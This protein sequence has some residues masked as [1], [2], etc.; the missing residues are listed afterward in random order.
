MTALAVG[1]TRRKSAI[2]LGPL[3]GRIL[4]LALL[5]LAAIW[6]G[7]NLVADP[8]RFSGS[9]LIGLQNGLLYALVA[10]GYTM[11]YGVI[12]LINFAH[13]DLFM[14][15]TIVAA[16]LMVSVFGVGHVGAAAVLPLVVAL[17]GCMAFGAAINVSAEFFAYRRLRTAPRLAPLMTAVGLSFVFRGIA[18]QDYVNGSA[19]KNWPIEWGGPIVEG[20]YLYK[21]LLVA[22]GHDAATARHEIHRQSDE[23]G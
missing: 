10:L 18:Q 21:L 12:E 17:V 22:S 5:A 19:Q 16:A 6:L 8:T 23:N 9:V 14:L 3:V 15:A 2:R 11:V 1:A 20:V 7:W 4:G 13:G